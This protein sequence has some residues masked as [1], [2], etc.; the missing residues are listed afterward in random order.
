[1]ISK[2]VAIKRYMGTSKPV[3]FAELKELLQADKAGYHWMAE[4]CA[5]ELGEELQPS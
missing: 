2:V 3:T 1:M 5:R 4:E